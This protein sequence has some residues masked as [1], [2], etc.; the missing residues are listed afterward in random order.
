MLLTAFR[1]RAFGCVVDAS[2]TLSPIHAL[3][4]PND[5]GKSTLLRALSMALESPNERRPLRS[6]ESVELVFE[7]GVVVRADASGRNASVGNEVI[8]APDFIAACAAGHRLMRLNTALSN[9]GGVL[10]PGSVTLLAPPLAK[11]LES[12]GTA[13]PLDQ[14]GLDEAAAWIRHAPIY[15][16][17]PD[18]LRASSPLVATTDIRLQDPRGQGLAGVLDAIRDRDNSVWQEMEGCVRRFFPA[19]RQLRV[20]AVGNGHK[21]VSILLEDGTPVPAVDLSEGMLYVLGI[22]AIVHSSPTSMVLLEEPENGLH[23]ARIRDVLALLRGLSTQ[24]PVLM[25]THS[26]LVVNELSEHEVTVV[27]RDAQGTHTRPLAET[28]D[29]AS[30]SRAYENGELWLS[31]G[32]AEGERGLVAEGE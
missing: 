11:K 13:T 20:S 14:A 32:D 25:A 26:P 15:R 7:N 2:V 10:R 9:G 8:A 3:I 1:V 16:L 22:L 27:T 29:Y 4:G 23:P 30:R 19:V 18:S 12:N 21:E 5:A 24:V 17:D 31:Y 28:T 6:G